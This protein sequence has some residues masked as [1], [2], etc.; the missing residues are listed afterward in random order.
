MK[1]YLQW[2]FS[3]YEGLPHRKVGYILADGHGLDILSI[4]T[5]TCYLY[6]FTFFDVKLKEM[7]KPNF[8]LKWEKN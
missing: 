4:N 5:N 7:D 8:F 1:I 3:I 6:P 2:L